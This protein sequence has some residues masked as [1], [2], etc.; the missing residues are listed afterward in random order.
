MHHVA[1]LDDVIL[2]LDADLA[3]LAALRLTAERDQILPL[4]DFGADE[5]LFE[6]GVDLPRGAGGHGPS[7]DGPGIPR[8]TARRKERDEPQ[9]IVARADHVEEPRLLQP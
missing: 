7:R 5:P 6:V 8:G 1:V 4:D 2:A 3:G 9:E